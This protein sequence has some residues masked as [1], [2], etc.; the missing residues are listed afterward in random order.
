MPLSLRITSYQRLT[1]G[2]QN[3]F[4]TDSDS[5]TIGRSAEND[6]AIPDPQRFLSG[7]HCKI[8]HRGEDFFLTDVSTNGVFMNGAADRIPRNETVQLVQGDRFRIGDYEFEVDL[9]VTGPSPELESET[10]SV[11]LFATSIEDDPFADPEPPAPA[12]PPEDFQKDPNEPL[13]HLDESQLGQ[14]V[15]IDSLLDLD[16]PE[17]PVSEEAGRRE[18]YSP[19]HEPFTPPEAVQ[20][21]A[22]PET[23]PPAADDGWSNIPDNWDEATGMFKTPDQEPAAAVPG[24]DS[25]HEIPDNW[26]EATGMFIAP[27]APAAK[28]EPPPQ[29]QAP[30]P[31]PP[32]AASPMPPPTPRAAPARQPAAAGGGGNAVAAF[33]RGAGLQ[34]G[35]IDASDTQAL[36]ELIGRMVKCTTE[37]LMKTL[38]GRTHI[39]SEFRLDQ[40]MIRPVE[41]NPLKFCPTAGDALMILLKQT[42]QAYK[43]GVDSIQEGFDDVNAH[44]MAVVAGMEAALQGIL[45]KFNPKSLERKLVSQSVLDNVLPGAK[46]A[47]YWDI[48]VLLY[49][50]IASDAEDDFQQLFGKEFSRAYEAQLNRLK[51]NRRE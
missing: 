50:E 28:P 4:R 21:P 18:P 22:G 5:F 40:T 12:A 32:P 6:W 23:V 14:G 15:D 39:K 24:G 1:P 37:G 29:P 2:Q 34:P 26:D 49:D 20:P 33:E 48:F 7:V 8:E 10:E 38:G 25:S 47:K 45:K 11:D 19:L 13:S 27:E 41:N 36:F 3:E 30:S 46:K 51:D 17:T 42:D 31:P 43:K 16:E 35:E 44:Q 9:S